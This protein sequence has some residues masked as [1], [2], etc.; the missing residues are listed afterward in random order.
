MTGTT[1]KAVAPIA[2]ARMETARTPR[3]T[4]P[5]RCVR[6]QG[7]SICRPASSAPDR[8]M[9]ALTTSALAIMMTM[10]SLNP[11]KA[12]SAGTT[13]TAVPAASPSAATMS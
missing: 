10:S 8:A 2:T 5:R 9:A 7:A 6:S 3:R 11:E 1:P 12:V 4:L 13:P